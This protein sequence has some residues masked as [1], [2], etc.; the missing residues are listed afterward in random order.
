M[1]IATLQAVNFYH[2]VL[3]RF[4]GFL[5]PVAPCRA[6]LTV[7]SSLCANCVVLKESREINEIIIKSNL[8]QLKWF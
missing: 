7:I 8:V 4:T 3:K 1:P 6:D 5:T 2:F